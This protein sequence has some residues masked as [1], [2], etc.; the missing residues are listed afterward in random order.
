VIQYEYNKNNAVVVVHMDA[1]EQTQ[2]LANGFLYDPAGNLLSLSLGNGL[3]H[4][5]T[6]NAGN[7]PVSITVPGV[8]DRAYS[9]DQNANINALEDML[10]PAKSASY[11][12]DALNRLTNKTDGTGGT[13]NVN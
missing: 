6:Y 12:Y 8:V 9:Y 1:V 3:E 13:I 4:L 7:S 10:D 5:W 11:S 2:V